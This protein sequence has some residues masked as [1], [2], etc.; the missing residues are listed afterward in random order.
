MRRHRRCR[1]IQR[2]Q[3]PVPFGIAGDAIV[4]L[5]AIGVGG[6][7]ARGNPLA[8]G[9]DYRCVVRQPC[10]CDLLAAQQALVAEAAADVGRDDPDGAIIQAEAFGNS[11]LHD[12]RHL[13]RADHGEAL[14]SRVPV[15]NDPP[16]LDRQHA[17]RA[18][19][20]SR[21]TLMAAVSA[22]RST[23]PSSKNSM[24]TLSSQSS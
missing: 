12:M 5:T 18:V 19:R 22:T 20:T 23:G 8:N 7:A 10:Q 14:Q 15:R 11:V 2:Q 9:H 6:S 1:A 16:P 4:V 3:P 17:C 13:A 24:K 21:V